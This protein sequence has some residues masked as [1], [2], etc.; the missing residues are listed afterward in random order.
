MLPSWLWRRRKGHEPKNAVSLHKLEKAREQSPL[1]PPEGAEP[2][3]TLI[4]AQEN[5]FKTSDLQ[6][7]EVVLRNL[8]FSSFRSILLW[9]RYN[10]S[11]ILTVAASSYAGCQSE[12]HASLGLKM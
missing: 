12:N 5:P 2:A 11:Q 4:L 9:K 10:H 6:N 3:D 1:E 8:L 7:C